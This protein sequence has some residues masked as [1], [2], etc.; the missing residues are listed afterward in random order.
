MHIKGNTVLA[1][2]EPKDL[3]QKLISDFWELGTTLISV[4]FYCCFAFKETKGFDSSTRKSTATIQYTK[5]L[6]SCPMP[7]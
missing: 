7:E 4:T 1:K 3:T 2:G 6:K 5:K